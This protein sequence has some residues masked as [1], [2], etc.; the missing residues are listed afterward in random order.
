MQ[1]RTYFGECL[2]KS[3]S[4]TLQSCLF[5][6]MVPTAEAS[7][8]TASSSKWEH[9]VV[10]TGAVCF[11][12]DQG[13]CLSCWLMLDWGMRSKGWT[14]ARV[15]VDHAQAVRSTRW[16]SA[17]MSTLQSREAAEVRI[18]SPHH[19]QD[20]YEWRAALWAWLGVERGLGSERE[21][22]SRVRRC[23]LLSLTFSH[24]AAGEHGSMV[25]RQ[26]P[27]GLPLAHIFIPRYHVFISDL[28]SIDNTF[29]VVKHL[30]FI[31]ESIHSWCGPHFFY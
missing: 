2:H 26:T 31:F 19:Q 6:Q 12:F 14:E 9:A 21:E 30:F 1:H 17:V 13:G 20:H 10:P 5:M 24:K 23:L 29:C 28:S 25:P 15:A 4:W 22:R 7:G 11:R 3:F 8:Q 16:N 27:T 18:K